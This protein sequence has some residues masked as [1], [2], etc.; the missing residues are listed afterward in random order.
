MSISIYHLPW[1]TIDLFIIGFLSLVFVGARVRNKYFRW[2]SRFPGDGS[3]LVFESTDIP[4]ARGLT[5]SGRIFW[6]KYGSRTG[7]CI[8]VLPP[9][10]KKAKRFDF[11]SASLALL[12]TPVCAVDVRPQG[13]GG[14]KSNAPLAFDNISRVLDFLRDHPR[15]SANEFV[16]VGFGSGGCV[17]LGKV[18]GEPTFRFVVGVGTI[19]ES[20]GSCPPFVPLGLDGR[21]LAN[22]T[23]LVHAKDDRIAPFPNFREFVREF[24]IEPQ[25]L[26]TFTRGGHRLRGQET[27]LVGAI[28]G[29]LGPLGGSEAGDGG[30]TGARG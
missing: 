29:W 5:V 18:L 2:T 3:H 27:M 11:L 12:G 15:I 10:G 1:L 20:D 24:G 17:L 26:V 4:A 16:G 6:E 13:K 22:K 30:T 7:T 19:F 23:R 21:E 8:V 14:W 9:L 28:A 25:N